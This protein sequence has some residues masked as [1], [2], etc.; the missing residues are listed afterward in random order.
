MSQQAD[1]Y[2]LQKKWDELPQDQRDNITK[3]VEVVKTKIKE[4]QKDDPDF[5]RRIP[6]D[7]DILFDTSHP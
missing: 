3:A 4:K 6:F 5:K 7:P 1:R 2:N